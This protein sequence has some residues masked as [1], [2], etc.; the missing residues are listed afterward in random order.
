MCKQFLL[1]S[2]IKLFLCFP[3][4]LGRESYAEVFK[5]ISNTLKMCRYCLHPTLIVV[6]QSLMHI[7]WNVLIFPDQTSAK[8][9][10]EKCY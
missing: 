9:N 6:S 1:F 2:S 4:I 8:K 5:I 10:S 7:L 3:F